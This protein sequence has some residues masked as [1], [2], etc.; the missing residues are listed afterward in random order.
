M[1][2]NDE[3]IKLMS[4]YLSGKPNHLR[5]LNIEGRSILKLILQK[6]GV[7]L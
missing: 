1:P 4:F 6:Q 5:E 3:F 2:E 7:I